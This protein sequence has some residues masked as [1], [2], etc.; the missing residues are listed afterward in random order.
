MPGIPPSNVKIILI[1]KSLPAPLFK[2]TES[3]GKNIF[4]IMVNID[5]TSF[6]KLK[7]TNINYFNIG[8]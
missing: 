4:R 3:G 5:I 1:I 7:H 8:I 6:I 2:N